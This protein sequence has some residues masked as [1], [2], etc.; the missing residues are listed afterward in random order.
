MPS[1]NRIDHHNFRDFIHKYMNTN[2]N[3]N[4]NNNNVSGDKV[5]D[6]NF[7]KYCVYEE[8]S[9]YKK[10]VIITSVADTKNLNNESIHKLEIYRDC[11]GHGHKMVFSQKVHAIRIV[12]IKS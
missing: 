6:D 4:I 1:I 12:T 11:F 8:N 5:S 3:T 2:T 7:L 9:D 10:S